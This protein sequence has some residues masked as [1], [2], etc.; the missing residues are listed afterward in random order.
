M[1][2]LSKKPVSVRQVSL[3]TLRVTCRL[4]AKLSGDGSLGAIKK[5][6]RKKMKELLAGKDSFPPATP[7][8]LPR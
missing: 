4:G 1:R 6:K 8:V 5:W 2:K 3:P 7:R